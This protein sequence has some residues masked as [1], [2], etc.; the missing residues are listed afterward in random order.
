MQGEGIHSC[1]ALAFEKIHQGENVYEVVRIIDGIPLFFEKHCHRLVRS[2]EFIN[3]HINPDPGALYPKIKTLVLKNGIFNG[4]LKIVLQ[5]PGTV[6][7]LFIFFIPHHYPGPHDYF[8]GVSLT[9]L[10]AERNSPNAKVSNPQLRSKANRIIKEKQ[11]AEVLLVDAN[12]FITEGSRSNIFFIRDESIFTP[13]LAQVLPGIT[14]ETVMEICRQSEIPLH[15]TKI[16]FADL[17]TFGGAFLTGTSP[18]VLPVRKIDELQ[19][20]VDIPLIRII[21]EKYDQE[22]SDYLLK[23]RRNLHPP[24]QD[25]S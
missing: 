9:S 24:K 17:E 15:E 5:K 11:V 7:D 1:T 14:R 3:I 12:G 16:E 8:A 10:L 18:K 23:A 25:I 13:A 6:D 21:M 20:R 19:F 4:N 22:I 2:A